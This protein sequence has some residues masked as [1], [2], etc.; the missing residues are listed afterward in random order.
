MSVP[1]I[2]LR[3]R[4]TIGYLRPP[5]AHTPGSSIPYVSTRHHTKWPDS[6]MILREGE[7]MGAGGRVTSIVRGSEAV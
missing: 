2:A 6:I 1:D 5:T 3:S 4:R 7:K